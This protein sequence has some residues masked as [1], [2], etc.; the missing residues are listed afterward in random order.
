MIIFQHNSCKAKYWCYVVVLA[1]N[2][3]PYQL[4][5]DKICNLLSRKFSIPN[6]LILKASILNALFL[7]AS[8]NTWSELVFFLKYI[9]LFHITNS[10]F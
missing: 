3:Y 7:N 2:T 8:V 1:N 9:S 4:I 6:A 5:S 10:Y